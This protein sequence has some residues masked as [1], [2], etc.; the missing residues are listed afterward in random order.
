[1][2]PDDFTALL[3]ARGI[4]YGRL[5]AL[6]VAAKY[7]NGPLDDGLFELVRIY[8]YLDHRV[9]ERLHA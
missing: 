1:M 3:D 5:S 4:V 2:T 6:V 8:A 9:R 7:D